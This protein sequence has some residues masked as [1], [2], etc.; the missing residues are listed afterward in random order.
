MI[1]FR[2]IT[3][4]NFLEIALLDPGEENLKYIQPN[5]MNM[6]SAHY[7]NNCIEMKAVYN[8][9]ILIGF[10]MLTTEIKP[11]YLDCFMIDK[12]YQ[13]KGYG[14]K[15]IKK[16]IRYVKNNYRVNNLV[17][18]TS[19]PIAF[20]LYKKNGFI[21]LHNKMADKYMKKYNEY[22]LTYNLLK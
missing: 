6:L 14:N 3:N 21:Q 8:N 1:T 20:N 15:C 12:K 5:W 2:N 17:L 13:N 16:I 19:N 11:L 22:L 7:I 9:K 18:S 10:F 4:N